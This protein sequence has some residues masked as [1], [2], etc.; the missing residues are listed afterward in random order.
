MIKIIISVSHKLYMRDNVG[1]DFFIWYNQSRVSS[2]HRT[3]SCTYCP[4]TFTRPP[5]PT[6]HVLCLCL[7]FNH[8]L[9]LKLRCCRPFVWCHWGGD[10]S[11]LAFWQNETRCT[12]ARPSVTPSLFFSGNL[13]LFFK[14]SRCHFGK[15]R[16]SG[17]A[18]IVSGSSS[19]H[20]G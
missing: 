6:S 9:P 10:K 15:I 16:R 14:R 11:E 19:L 8:L 20:W 2:R 4:S 5:P 17:E 18:L 12:S 3:R 7:A 1:S 13:V